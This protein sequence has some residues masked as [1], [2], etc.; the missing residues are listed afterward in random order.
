VSEQ[1]RW[2]VP[3]RAGLAGRPTAIRYHLMAGQWDESA[4]FQP[5]R[6]GGGIV[7]PYR[8]RV[9]LSQV[10]QDCQAAPAQ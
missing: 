4:T 9:P 2:T 5:I 7:F 10:C 8:E 3:E 6:C 1:M